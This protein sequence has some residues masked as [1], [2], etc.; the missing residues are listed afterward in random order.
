MINT[1]LT[2]EKISHIPQILQFCSGEID[3]MTVLISAESKQWEANMQ[4]SVKNCYCNWL[5][6]QFQCDLMDA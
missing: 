2:E 6:L 4:V 3:S 5:K 1:L